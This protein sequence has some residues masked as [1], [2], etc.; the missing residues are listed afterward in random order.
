MLNLD[1]YFIAE[2]R[3]QRTIEV[4]QLEIKK[5]EF[6][7]QHKQELEAK[8]VI[9][10]FMIEKGK[11]AYT[12]EGLQAFDKPSLMILYKWKYCKAASGLNKEKIREA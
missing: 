4:N 12:N 7:E 10:K 1:D 8:T 3:K 2:E 11:D 5:E 6:E 9:D